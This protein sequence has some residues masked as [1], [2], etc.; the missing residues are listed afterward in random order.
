MYKGALSFACGVIALGATY[1]PASAQN[2]VSH[3]ELGT[4]F[5]GTKLHGDSDKNKWSLG[6]GIGARLAKTS[7]LSWAGDIALQRYQGDLYQTNSLMLKLGCE[8]NWFAYNGYREQSAWTPYIGLGLGAVYAWETRAVLSPLLYS[9]AGI[10]FR[11]SPRS[12]FQV[13]YTWH[14]ATS[15]RLDALGANPHLGQPIGLASSALRHGDALST[16]SLSWF[17]RIGKDNINCN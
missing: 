11:L 9:S 2:K 7:Q 3:L 4:T 8:Y 1:T 17:W 12:S 15:D 14:Y 13:A 5:Y 16:L 10:K 6:I